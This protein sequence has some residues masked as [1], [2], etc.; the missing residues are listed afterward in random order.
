MVHENVE[1]IRTAKGITKTF[2]ANKL[3]LSLQG[4]RH[5]ASGN[6][7]LDTE[8]LKVI[9]EVLGEDPAIFLSNELTESVIN[10]LSGKIASTA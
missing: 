4:Y 9:G 10:R 1:K 2:V 3:E 6:V 5:I 8:R 7:R